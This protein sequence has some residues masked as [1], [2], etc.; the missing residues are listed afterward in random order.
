MVVLLFCG[1]RLFGSKCKIIN[2]DVTR[3][4]AINVNVNGNDVLIVNVY[5]SCDSPENANEFVSYLTILDN[6][7]E[8][9]CSPYVYFI[10]DFNAN[11]LKNDEGRMHTQFGRELLNFCKDEGYIV[12]DMVLLQPTSYT[13]VS[14]AHGTV[15][16]LDHVITTASAHEIIDCIKIDTSFVSSDH[17]PLCVHLR[18]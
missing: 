2:Y 8:N 12:S 16:W 6:I 18:C 9:H 1:G 7:V 14:L 4:L 11:L 10:G 5:L 13:F 3:I 15:S 17:C